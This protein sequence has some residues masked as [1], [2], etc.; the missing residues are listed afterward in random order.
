MQKLLYRTDNDNFQALFI[1]TAMNHVSKLTFT[2]RDEY[3]VWVKRWKEDYRN[4]VHLYTIKKY[5]THPTQLKERTK[6]YIDKVNHLKAESG[7]WPLSDTVKRVKDI[8]AQ[9][10]KEYGCYV[11]SNNLYAVILYFLMVR[12]AAKIRANQQRNVRLLSKVIV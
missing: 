4:I 2:T 6:W 11:C 8:I 3:L 12:K 7:Y 1:Q 5:E 9:M 10:S